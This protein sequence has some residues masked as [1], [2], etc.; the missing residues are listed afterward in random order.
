MRMRREQLRT[1]DHPLPLVVVEPILT[2]LEAGY[3]GMPRRR[4]MFGCMLTRRTVTASDMSTLRASTEMKPPAL[5]RRQAFYTSVATGFRCRVDSA[6]LVFHF[7]LSSRPC[8]SRKRLQATSKTSP[9]MAEN[10]P[11]IQHGC[12]RYDSH[13][14]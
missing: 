11:S 10:P 12:S 14:K 4:R 6:P 3:D 7:T 9:S 5:R 13:L 8:M 1:F 2:R